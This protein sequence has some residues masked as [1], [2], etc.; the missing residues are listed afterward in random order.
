MKQY[1][2]IP[3]W[4]KIH[5]GGDCVA[6]YKEDGTNMRFEW[7]KKRNKWYKF[8]TRNNVITLNDEI[9]GQGIEIFLEKYSEKL[10]DV[11]HTKYKN[12]ESVVVFCE[13]FGE[14]S[15]AGQHYHNDKKEL[16]LFDVSLYKR[17]FVSPYEFIDN[18]GHLD[19]TKVIYQGKYNNELVDN[20]RNNIFCLNEGVICKG[21]IEKTIWQSKIKTNT[22]LERLEKEKGKKSILEEFS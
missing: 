19:I 20:V 3:H 2:K 13:Y 16:R 11:F 21:I 8:G 6:F 15:F 22:W 10:I 17:G 9:Y 4:Y 7:S 1:P 14:N 18:F 12:V 5:F